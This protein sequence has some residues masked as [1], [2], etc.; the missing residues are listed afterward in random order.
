MNEMEKFMMQ[1]AA[2][3]GRVVLASMFMPLGVFSRCPTKSKA[4]LKR[5]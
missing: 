4:A 2:H 3:F 1:L 5:R